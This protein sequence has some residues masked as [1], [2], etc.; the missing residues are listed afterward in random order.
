MNLH[1][2]SMDSRLRKRYY[3]PYIGIVIDRLDPKTLQR[4]RLIV[5]EIGIV[6]PNKTDWALP[7]TSPVSGVADVGNVQVP[8]IGAQVMVWFQGGNADRPVYG[9]GVVGYPRGVSDTPKLAQGIIPDDMLGKQPSD[10]DS[11]KDSALGVRNQ[12]DNPQKS[13]YPDNHIL[14]LPNGIVIEYDATES[15]P[16]IHIYHPTGSFIEMDKDGDVVSKTANDKWDTIGGDKLEHI[17]GDNI[18]TSNGDEL[19]RVQGDR[20]VN[21][22]GDELK[23]VE[24]GADHSYEGNHSEDVTEAWDKDVGG[25]MTFTIGDLAKIVAKQIELDGGTGVNERSGVVTGECID[26]FTGIPYAD[27]STN[28]RASK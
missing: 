14:R 9:G 27:I 25:A 20:E 24:G 13:K 2:K 21:V 16:R 23:V 15:E 17:K 4:V 3:G 6:A 12:K 1:D 26:S 10:L 11:F 7:T 28:V 8:Q 18:H 22:V 19:H 5:P